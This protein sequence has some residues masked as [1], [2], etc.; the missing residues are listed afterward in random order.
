MIPN[1]S[2][3]WR[4]AFS[5]AFLGGVLWQV[6]KAGFV[7]FI[8]SGLINYGLVYGSLASVVTLMLWTYLSAAIL[9]IG[10]AFGYVFEMHYQSRIS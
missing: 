5:G 10:A 8:T 9:F 4:F 6:A 2:V 7:W 3:P 1:R